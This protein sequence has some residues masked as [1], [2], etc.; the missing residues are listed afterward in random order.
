MRK[1]HL[2]NA[3]C[4]GI[5]SAVSQ[6]SLAVGISG[7]GALGAAQ[8]ALYFDSG[9]SIMERYHETVPDIS[10]MANAGVVGRLEWTAVNAWSA[11]SGAGTGNR[12]LPSRI[13]NYDPS[14][15]ETDCYIPPDY[16]PCL[17]DGGPFSD[18]FTRAL[19]IWPTVAYS[20]GIEISCISGFIGGRQ[21]CREKIV[22]DC[23]NTRVVPDGD[24]GEPAIPG[25]SSIWFLS[26]GLLGMVAVARRRKGV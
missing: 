23:C 22:Y 11:S 21:L 1:P 25:A 6:S 7:Q 26:S 15:T 24:A 19:A 18:A 14:S 12:R 17:T 9:A 16:L 4:A 20:Q 8:N 10:W 5:I 2:F 3:L 13:A